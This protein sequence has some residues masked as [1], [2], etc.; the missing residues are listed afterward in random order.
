MVPCN[1]GAHQCTHN[2]KHLWLFLGLNILVI[3]LLVITLFNTGNSW[4]Q[5]K[6][7]N[8]VADD[9]HKPFPFFKS[10]LPARHIVQNY[11]KW[12]VC[13]FRAAVN[14]IIWMQYCSICTYKLW[15]HRA[16]MITCHMKFPF[17]NQIG[18]KQHASMTKTKCQLI[19]Y[20]KTSFINTSIITSIE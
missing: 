8:C 18:L 11:E 17:E 4:G 10:L 9:E 7:R 5:C 1:F 6:L 2:G 15:A 14:I 12:R 20:E 16:I 13:I 3:T 19:N